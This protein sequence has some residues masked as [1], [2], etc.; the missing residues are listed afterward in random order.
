MD[1]ALLGPLEARDARRG[2]IDLGS[3]RQRAVLAMLLLDAGRVVSIERLVDG[4][5][6]DDPPAKA[7]AS[8][9]SYVSNLRR[10]LEPDRPPRAPARLLVSRGRGY[11]VD[12]VGDAH[13][14]DLDRFAAS[15]DR[16]DQLRGDDPEHALAAI[17][18]ALALWRGPALADV[19]HEPFAVAEA[20]RLE[21]QRAA[22]EEDRAGLLLSL[23]RASEALAA[24]ERMVGLDPLRERAQHLLVLALYRLGRQVDA[25]E[26][27][28]RHVRELA[29]DYGLDPSP[30]YLALHDAILRHELAGPATAP[31]ASPIQPASPPVEVGRGPG[32][33]DAIPALLAPPPAPLLRS[34]DTLVGRGAELARLRSA[35][36]GLQNGRGAVVLVSGEAGIGKTRL[37]EATLS[38]A[39]DR[40]MLA[41]LGRC[42]EDGGAPA[43]WPFVEIARSLRASVAADLAP[44][45]DEL[46]GLLEPEPDVGGDRP[47]STV[48]ESRTRFLIADRLVASISAIA[49]SRPVVIAVDD[50]YGAD[51]DSLDGLV[52]LA[53]AAERRPVLVLASFRTSA[54]PDGHP[55]AHTLGELVRRASVERIAPRR[56]DLGETRVLLSR[57]SGTSIDEDTARRVLQRAAGNPFFTVELGRLLRDHGGD[58]SCEVPDAVRDLL[59]QRLG[60]LPAD[61]Q[62]ILRVAAVQ[63]RTF[64]V[65]VLAE[66]EDAP[67][68]RVIEHLERA[69]AAQL[70]VEDRTRPGAFRFAHVLVRDAIAETLTAVRRAEL[71]AAVATSLRHTAEA[72]PATWVEV[73]HHAVQAV[74]L[75]GADQA[76]TALR[77]A[78]LHA[79]S[80]NAHE[81]A[82]QLVLQRLELVGTLPAGEERDRIELDAQLD[83]CAMIPITTGWHAPELETAGERACE[84]A[85]RLGDHDAS[86]QGMAALSANSTV[87]ARYDRSL[88]IHPRQLAIHAETGD[89]AHG[90]VACHAAA[91]VHLFLGDLERADEVYRQGEAFIREADPF[92]EGLIRIAPD[93]MNG[94]AH[95]ASLWAIALWLRGDVDAA[96]A[97]LDRAHGL[98]H[99]DGHA[100]TIWT[101]WLSHLI[102]RYCAD[103][104]EAVLAGDRR[105]LEEA[106]DLT[107]PL[108]DALIGVPVA[109]AR[110]RTGEPSLVDRMAQLSRAMTDDGA[111]VFAALYRGMLADACLAAG[112]AEDALAA[113]DDGLAWADRL[114]ERMWEAELHRL[115]ALALHHLGRADDAREALTAAEAVARRQGAASLA[116]RIERT[117]GELGATV[118]R[119]PV[120]A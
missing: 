95:H 71:H 23:G 101:V 68:L 7:L 53:A 84:L 88:A 6:G 57:E 90:F 106:A 33:V 59:R 100:Q 15:L 30:A 45:L 81:Q 22:A 31:T 9:Q 37:L 78:A 26:A 112:R 115:R 41:A 66:V 34:G 103:D 111:R 18:E 14:L 11:V 25:L 56:L 120:P 97:Q 79:A 43:F 5:W 10:L 2:P 39:A 50:L 102:T 105:R 42:Y 46:L 67:R 28:R 61:T 51:P 40:G 94:A 8:L 98:A 70:V 109:W 32:A 117:G 85:E 114:R 58:P 48:L 93:R 19:A 24:V 75:T 80:V 64:T 69:T 44:A 13:S 63:G 52:R 82:H 21:A 55:L 20:A 49:A 83:R 96:E 72:H 12:L 16:A 76:I 4:L 73:A 77:R 36:D 74:D 29:D 27:H 17:D 104:P 99:R 92:D 65:D 38:E 119:R 110:V 87:S 35:V 108:V 89:P 86:L 107:S 47:L 1:F 116:A 113:S 54:L 62:R 91:M 118:A 60:T 3:P